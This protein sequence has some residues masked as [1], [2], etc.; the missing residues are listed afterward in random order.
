MFGPGSTTQ[1]NS[2]IASP[3]RER[4]GHTNEDRLGD[5][6]GAFL[7]R[8]F[9]QAFHPG[10]SSTQGDTGFT[11]L[12][13]AFSSG[14]SG[15]GGRRSGSSWVQATPATGRPRPFRRPRQLPVPFF[16]GLYVLGRKVWRSKPLEAWRPSPG[17]YGQSLPTGW[18]P[19]VGPS[20]HPSL[21]SSPPQWPLCRPPCP[22]P[23]PAPHPPSPLPVRSRQARRPPPWLESRLPGRL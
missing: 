5:L 4:H 14:H 19:Q 18:G 23:A 8:S 11:T 21:G 16:R 6:P 15:R 3:S 20:C 1:A 12:G 13:C 17:R 9:I 22:W 7:G 2:S 10:L